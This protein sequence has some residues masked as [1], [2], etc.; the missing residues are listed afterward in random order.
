[1]KGI[2]NSSCVWEHKIA[3][4]KY[5]EPV[6]AEPVII[7]CSSGKS[8]SFK[9][10]DVGLVK[11]EESYYIHHTAGVSDGDMLDGHIVSV[12]TFVDTL[13]TVSYYKAVVLT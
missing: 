9:R 5:N 2:L 8:V 13:G 11:V 3:E 4:N 10:T 6:Y 12:G 1:M 7:P